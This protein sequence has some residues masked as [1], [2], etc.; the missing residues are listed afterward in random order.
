MSRRR[1]RRR[2]ESR[3][4]CHAERSLAIGEPLLGPP[5]PDAEGDG[6]ADDSE[7]RRPVADWSG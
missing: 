6:G 7:L 5:D 2:G 3:V 4:G 1:W